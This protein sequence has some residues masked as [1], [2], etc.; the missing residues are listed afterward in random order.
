MNAMHRQ[1]GPLTAGAAI[2]AS[3][4]LA[5][6]LFAAFAIHNGYTQRSVLAVA[7]GNS[8]AGCFLGLGA[9][10]LL[11][12][13]TIAGNRWIR[14]LFRPI[15]FCTIP[16]LLVAKS[17]EHYGYRELLSG[18]GFWFCVVVIPL[19]GLWVAWRSPL[20]SGKSADS[21]KD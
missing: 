11:R 10:S 20:P 9:E 15:A 1:F 4:G 18:F 19:A 6:G 8:M 7:I 13:P 16:Y 14:H 21:I 17:L 2:G 12:H 3:L 5:I